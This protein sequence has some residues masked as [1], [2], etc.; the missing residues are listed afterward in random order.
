MTAEVL[1]P[2]TYHHIDKKTWPVGPWRSE[3]DK[4]QW[5]DGETN[6]PCLIVRNPGSGH[7]CGYV[8]VTQWHPLFAVDYSQCPEKCGES[9]CS[10]SPESVLDVHGGITFTDFCQE[11]KEETGICHIPEPGQP[12][13]VW[14]FGFDCAHSGD[15]GPIYDKPDYG[16]YRTVEYVQYEC[17]RLAKQLAEMSNATKTP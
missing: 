15:R 16:E 6:L 4:M 2:R 3:P 9:W 1:N 12:D 5:T 14:W 7:L 11:G 8:G 10:H 17:A 13:R